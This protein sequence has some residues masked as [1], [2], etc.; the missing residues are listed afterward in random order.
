MSQVLSATQTNQGPESN[1]SPLTIGGV[2]FKSRLLLGSGRYA[3]LEVMQRAIA[4]SG[5]DAVTVAVRRE[6][7]ND[8]AGRNV[9]DF[10]DPSQFKIIPNTAGCYDAETAIRCARMGREILK[11]IG[12]EHTDLVKLEVLGDGRTLLPDPIESLRATEQ[13]VREGFRVLCYCSDDPILA[14]RLFQ[15]GVAA[16]MPAGS[17][18]GSGGGIANPNH[19]RI[20][21]EDIKAQQKDFPII[22]DAGIRTASDAALAM[23]LGADGVLMN[24]AVALASDPVI[25]AGGMNLA[26]I[27]GRLTFLAKPM[28]KN[29]FASASS[30]EFG[31]I[32]TKRR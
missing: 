23:E 3:S 19:L 17:P 13:L 25:M 16:V 15:A 30:P 10:L 32:T 27:A 7:L 14:R 31:V 20:I 5:T 2:E 11:T 22:V 6:R 21:V 26:V 8:G 24:S 28:E 12:C 9:I 29:S 18:I 4:A 1:D